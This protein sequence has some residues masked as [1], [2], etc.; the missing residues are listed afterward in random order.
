[1]PT[2]TPT[3]DP[4]LLHRCSA[5]CE[6][7]V[8][9]G[10]VSFFCGWD[11]E[12]SQ[13]R[14]GFVT[15]AAESSL[16][17]ESFL[18]GCGHH[19]VQPT[20]A[21]TVEPSH[22]PTVGPTMLPTSFPTNLPSLRPTAFPS[23]SPSLNPTSGPSWHPSTDP[24][25][26]P[27]TFPSMVPSDAPTTDPCLDT[28]CSNDCEGA[29]VANSVSFFCGW[30]IES[31]TCRAG[32]TT[33]VEESAAMHESS[34]G[35]CSHH[36]LP[37]TAIPTIT[38]TKSPS[39]LP[40]FTPSATPTEEPTGRPTSHPSSTPSVTPS[41]GPSTLPTQQPT[42]TPTRH[43]STGPSVL[44]TFRPSVSPSKA[45]TTL[46]PSP[47]P[48]QA[49]STDPCLAFR[50]SSDCQSS[51]ASA[52]VPRPTDHTCGWDSQTMLCRVG[53]V[54]EAEESTAM[55]ESSPGD[56]R[57]H[58]FE[59]TTGPT[60]QPSR[61]PTSRP[62]ARPS[63]NPS[64]TAPSTTPSPN[65][66]SSPSAAP[67]RHPTL[68]PSGAPSKRPT[69]PLP[70]ISPTAQPLQERT[71]CVGVGGYCASVMI[72]GGIR[73]N[74]ECCNASLVCDRSA[75]RV[76]QPST[77]VGTTPD[78]TTGPGMSSAGPSSTSTQEPQFPT[79][80]SFVTI[81]GNA[82]MQASLGS[83]ERSDA[84]IV[85]LVCGIIIMCLIL[86]CICMRLRHTQR[87]R[88]AREQIEAAKGFGQYAMAAGGPMFSPHN[89]MVGSPDHTYLHGQAGSPRAQA[90]Y[91]SASA[92]SN[93]RSNPMR[94]EGVPVHNMDVFAANGSARW[95]PRS[96]HGRRVGFADQE[97]VYSDA[98]S[99]SVRDPCVGSHHADTHADAPFNRVGARSPFS[100]LSESSSTS[101]LAKPRRPPPGY[102]D[103]RT[104]TP[105]HVAGM[106][107]AM[108][109]A[110][111]FDVMYLNRQETMQP[112]KFRLAGPQAT[113]RPVLAHQRSGLLD[114][115]R[116]PSLDYDTTEF[117]DMIA[118]GG[119]VGTVP[120]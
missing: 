20:I 30:D 96:P 67:A 112:K 40:T 82:D 1:M 44:P 21:P 9:A 113:L 63:S 88:D 59:P 33:T 80:Q 92:H 18:G 120:T 119:S 109:D 51:S 4:C 52:S 98:S 65:P 39:R 95:E 86:G 46:V 35:D 36:T 99:M 13:C 78:L 64:A 91:E 34:T 100:D 85:G 47:P 55:L 29:V 97:H 103:H 75:C 84:T 16:L 28:R 108:E 10:T 93:M 110:N 38:P 43:P 41:R 58:T 27:T 114:N 50:C 102:I 14:R 31:M 6:G 90:I 106:E 19:T 104:E 101:T 89:W 71:L 94:H 73:M 48:S 26:G 12:S 53:Y 11:S 107:A 62:S 49:P 115:Q 61:R 74:F 54:T 8:T 22:T 117:F 118:D 87:E 56:C 68:P 116:L 70:T 7:R 76:P 57:H 3:A 60:P 42:K 105:F 83:E 77:T 69:L 72:G 17:L 24:S 79:D 66:S 32:F 37:P 15:T 111:R 45:P 23:T 81:D 2:W 5:D 25:A